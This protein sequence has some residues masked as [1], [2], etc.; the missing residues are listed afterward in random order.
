MNNIETGIGERLAKAGGTMTGV[1][2]L[3]RGNCI[4]PSTNTYP[5]D[6]DDQMGFGIGGSVYNGFLSAE[7]A[8]MFVGG[9]FHAG[10]NWYYDNSDYRY[11]TDTRPAAEFAITTSTGPNTVTVKLRLSNGTPVEGG[12]IT[13]YSWHTL[14]TYTN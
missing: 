1:L 11:M 3:T 14:Y 7:Y 5:G 9:E 10:V 12:V 6:I 13:W 2:N 4:K 8:L